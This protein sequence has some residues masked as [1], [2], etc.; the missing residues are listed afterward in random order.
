MSLIRKGL[1]SPSG[2]ANRIIVTQPADLS[3]ILDST[4]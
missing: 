2:L 1:V 4:K 3:G